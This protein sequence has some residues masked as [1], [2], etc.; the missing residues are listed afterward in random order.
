MTRKCPRCGEVFSR[1]GRE[2]MSICKKCNSERV[3]S[4][5]PEYKMRNRAQIR[6]K[7]KNLE[8]NLEVSDI[9]IPKTCPVMGIPMFHHPKCIG[10]KHDSPSLDRID[11]SKGYIKGNVQ[12]IS[13]I[14]NRMKFDASPEELLKFA[15]WV[16]KTY[17]PEENY[18]LF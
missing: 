2:T 1:E 10:G 18:D 16:Y 6:A 8:F 9:V 17:K 7:R 5:S 3:K 13:M 14:A 12:V 11:N 4:K 15:D